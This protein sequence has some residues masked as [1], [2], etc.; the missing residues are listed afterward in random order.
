[1]GDAGIALN[2]LMIAAAAAK[3]NRAERNRPALGLSPQG[4]LGRHQVTA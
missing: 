2:E 4:A 1:L 3:R